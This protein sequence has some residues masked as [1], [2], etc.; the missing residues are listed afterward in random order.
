MNPSKIK[1]VLVV[2]GIPENDITITS[3]TTLSLLCPLSPWTHQK[4]KERN[5]S[6]GIKYDAER[7]PIYHC[8]G[9]GRK[10]LLYK[11]AVELGMLSSNEALIEVSQEIK[12]LCTPT[13]SSKIE[14]LD[15]TEFSVKKQ[16]ELLLLGDAFVNSF[17]DLSPSTKTY[18]KT[19]NILPEIAEEYALV[20]DPSRARLVFPVFTEK[21]LVSAVGRTLTNDARK[22]YNYPGAAL[23]L[24]IGGQ[25]QMKSSRKRLVLVE[26]FLDMLRVAPFAWRASCDVGCVWKASA[27]SAQVS[28]LQN[29]N[30]SISIWFDMDKAGKAGWTATQQKMCH[31]YGVRRQTWP[32]DWGD[33]GDLQDAQIEQ[34]MHEAWTSV[35]P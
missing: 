31:L 34:L 22:Y 18:L 14:N 28:I 8:F 5:A 20:E 26:G 4:G 17:T 11:L 13:L 15:L 16:P 35:A 27:S 21:G 30:K 3:P 12:Q 1:E 19:R 29:L 7:G 33:P 2:M 23:S 25:L 6:F 9:C 24:T 10:G 32:E